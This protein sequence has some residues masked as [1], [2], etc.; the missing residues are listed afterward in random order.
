MNK[1][2][3]TDTLIDVAAEF[4]EFELQYKDS[5]RL[6]RAIDIALKVI[7]LGNA[8]GF[9][10]D[11]VTTLGYKVYLPLDWVAMPDETKACVLRHEAVHMRQRRKYGMVLFALLYL[12]IPLP[13]G[14]AY[15]RT[16]FEKEAYA[17]SM[18]CAFRFYERGAYLLTDPR[19]KDR[20]VSQFTGPGYLW[21][22]PFRGS[23]SRWFDRVRDDIM[24]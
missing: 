18:R 5:S 10:S 13:I 17:E 24:R 23:V 14:L 4:P 16:K 8:R 15:Y 12:F 7:S 3:Y 22:W 2:V 6:M 19:Y 9:M 1:T 11:Y 20:I 21:M